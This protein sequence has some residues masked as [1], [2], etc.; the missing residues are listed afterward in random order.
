MGFQKQALQMIIDTNTYFSILDPELAED[1]G[2]TVAPESFDVNKLTLFTVLV[3]RSS[4]PEKSGT[5]RA[6]EQ[7]GLTVEQM[8]GVNL[9]Q[10]PVLYH[11]EFFVLW[12]QTKTGEGQRYLNR[13]ELLNETGKM[14]F[15][16]KVY[17]QCVYYD[18][19]ISSFY[20]VVSPGTDQEE[21]LPIKTKTCL[22][23]AIEIFI[24][25]F[26]LSQKDNFPIRVNY[27]YDPT[28]DMFLSVDEI[29][30]ED[31]YIAGSNKRLFSKQIE[32][33]NNYGTD[34]LQE[35]VIFS[36]TSVSIDPAGYAYNSS[37][38]TLN[39]N[40]FI[41]AGDCIWFPRD[42]WHFE[43]S[44]LDY[45]VTKDSVVTYNNAPADVLTVVPGNTLITTRDGWYS[46]DYTRW[47]TKTIR[48]IS[49]NSYMSERSFSSR[50]ETTFEK[51]N[52]DN[53]IPH[54]TEYNDDI[55]YYIRTE[56]PDSY[57]SGALAVGVGFICKII[58]APSSYTE[59]ITKDEQTKTSEVTIIRGD[60]QVEARISNRYIRDP[61]KVWLNVS[62]TGG[63]VYPYEFLATRSACEDL[64][65][66]NDVPGFQAK[67]LAIIETEIPA[68]YPGKHVSDIS[69]GAYNSKFNQSPT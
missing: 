33:D 51:T 17:A 58:W 37:I 48:T 50:Y 27:Y 28:N 53:G 35:R 41:P 2:F 20:Y 16:D 68:L 54:Y 15:E 65:S 52:L 43:Y 4:D 25:I 64:I 7:F 47:T 10:M 1:Q 59:F 21:T 13:L 9:Q 14:A 69:I 26:D 49:V 63:L 56:V 60:L 61:D 62:P 36:G 19:G 67:L 39:Q 30:W 6:L 40:K 34:S 66:H 46:D 8:V 55:G 12:L 57:V 24:I 5:I 45:T 31:Y 11:C 23:P 29:V 22:K 32:L 38:T 3:D 44:R 42:H 18:D